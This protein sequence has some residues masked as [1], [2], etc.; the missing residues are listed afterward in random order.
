MEYIHIIT[1]DEKEI[2]I[3]ANFLMMEKS[4]AGY[5]IYVIGTSYVDTSP[6][7]QGPTTITY[8]VDQMTFTAVFER[9]KGASIARDVL[10]N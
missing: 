7:A 8:Q 1:I 6:F 3:P 9:L 5:F 4:K 2:V 10:D